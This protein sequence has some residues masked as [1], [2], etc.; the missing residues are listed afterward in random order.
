MSGP[1]IIYLFTMDNS[2]IPKAPKAM[3]VPRAPRAMLM[4]YLA[5]RLLPVRVRDPRKAAPPQPPSN[6]FAEEQTR[7]KL[8]GLHIQ[9]SPQRIL[10]TEA[11][12]DSP[13]GRGVVMAGAT[14]QGPPKQKVKDIIT[15]FRAVKVYHLIVQLKD[16]LD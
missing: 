1:V 11:K 10:V 16:R 4:E 7:Q 12:S 5:A 13:P 14:P 2:E 6:G 8:G 15:S 9:S 3:L